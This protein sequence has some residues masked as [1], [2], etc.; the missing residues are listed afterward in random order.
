MPCTSEVHSIIDFDSYKSSEWLWSSISLPKITP[1]YPSPSSLYTFWGVLP[2]FHPFISDY[3]L[4]ICAFRNLKTIAYLHLQ[5]F[6]IPIQN[7]T[8]FTLKSD[9][10]K[11]KLKFAITR[12]QLTE[13]RAVGRWED[14]RSEDR[15]RNPGTTGYLKVK[16]SRLRGLKGGSTD[17]ETR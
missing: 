8:L 4:G 11:V 12:I 9:L 15:L 17:E 3:S 13:A 2:A 1:F 14:R 7:L 10:Q 16:G 5:Y 6:R